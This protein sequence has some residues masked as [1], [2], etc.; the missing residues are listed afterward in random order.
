MYTVIFGFTRIVFNNLI[1]I[2]AI[3]SLKVYFWPFLDAFFSNFDI[4][5]MLV[6][7]LCDIGQT[8]ANHLGPSRGFLFRKVLL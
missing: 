1:K 5:K 4:I 7:H 6:S 2:L 8:L 3:A